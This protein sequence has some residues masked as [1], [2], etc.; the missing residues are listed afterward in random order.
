MR[1]VVV[2]PPEPVIS[3]EEAAQHLKLG[4]NQAERALVEGM[5]AAATA[6]IDGPDGWLGRSLGAQTIQARLDAFHGSEIRLPYG[7]VLDLVSVEYL[8]A[9]DE[10]VQADPD[11]FDLLGDVIVP[12]GSE[13][14]WAGC[15]T[16]REAIRIEYLAGYED[17]IPPAA[18]AALLLMI[19]DLYRNRDT[20]AVVQMSKVPMS[21]SVESLLEPLRVYR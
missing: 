11:D 8:N 4:G 5:I 9:S 7:P 21:T 17:A 15:S 3:F 16:R 13:W 10:P 6:T 20:T 1:V 19:G 18:R 2:T 14:P 12:F